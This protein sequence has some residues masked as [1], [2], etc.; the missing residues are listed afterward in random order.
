M[1]SRNS[2][3]LLIG[4]IFASI[5]GFLAVH[6]FALEAALAQVSVSIKPA[7]ADIKVN[8]TQQFVAIVFGTPDQRVT[9]FR[10]PIRSLTMGL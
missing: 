2:N 3:L 4:P 5:V 7:Q 8:Q 10:A 9:S 1:V 6:I